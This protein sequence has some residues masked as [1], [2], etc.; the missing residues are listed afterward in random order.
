MT[1]TLTLE[2]VITQRLVGQSKWLKQ[3]IQIRHDFKKILN[4]PGAI[5]GAFYNRILGFEVRATLRQTQAVV[6]AELELRTAGLRVCRADHLVTLRLLKSEILPLI[7]V[8][9]RVLCHE[10]MDRLIVIVAH[11]QQELENCV[12]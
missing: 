6:L 9:T 1:F 4:C 8:F 2:V 10:N 7:L 12:Y 3:I 11:W 5:E